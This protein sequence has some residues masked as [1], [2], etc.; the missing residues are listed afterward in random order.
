M[1]FF[2]AFAL[3]ISLLSKPKTLSFQNIDIQTE[4]PPRSNFADTVN[5]WVIYDAYVSYEYAKELQDEKDRARSKKDE[6]N[7]TIK[8]LLGTKQID[9]NAEVNRKLLKAA[10]ILERMVNQNTYNDIA[11]DFKYW[12]DA[13]DEFRETEGTLLPL[14]RFVFEKAK[15]LEITSLCWNPAYKDLFAAA[16]GSCKVIHTL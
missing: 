13:S 9:R 4:P 12:E 16:F 8:R 1:W 6:S 5:Q 3:F 11:Q 14:W 10:K 2:S 15:G 7:Q